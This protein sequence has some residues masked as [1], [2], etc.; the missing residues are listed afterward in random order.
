MLSSMHRD[1]RRSFDAGTASGAR[2]L[3]QGTS[4]ARELAQCSPYAC[5]CA[6]R[7][8]S[9][10]LPAGV[11]CRPLTPPQQTGGEAAAAC[12]GGVPRGPQQTCSEAPRDTAQPHTWT[13]LLDGFANRS[14][15]AV[16]ATSDSHEKLVAM[17]AL[18]ASL[19]QYAS[20]LGSPTPVAA[21]PEPSAASPIADGVRKNGGAPEN[22]DR[23]GD[24][25]SAGGAA[26]PPMPHDLARGVFE[27]V[28]ACQ[29]D[30]LKLVPAAAAQVFAALC[31]IA[32]TTQVRGP[33]SPALI[34]A[35]SALAPPGAH[36]S[37]WRVR[38]PCSVT[39]VVSY[40]SYVMRHAM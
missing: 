12:D 27:L 23:D 7:A 26:V 36:R 5:M 11:L 34:R 2:I 22:T 17:T 35:L 10:L 1:L 15:A 21:G 38:M 25:V 6:I 31:A 13:L 16:R 32:A 14:M 9:A 3:L 8:L 30:S 18:L 40:D 20:L 4:V 33:V 29:G 39:A 37:C 24:D 19:Q 28:L